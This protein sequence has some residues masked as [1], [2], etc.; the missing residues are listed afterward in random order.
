LYIYIYIY[1]YAV[2]DHIFGDLPSNNSVY[3]PYII[4]KAVYTPYIYGIYMVCGLTNPTDRA[5]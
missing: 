2:Y 4:Y 3:T 5:W 1:I